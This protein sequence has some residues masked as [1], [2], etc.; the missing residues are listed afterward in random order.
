LH[1]IVGASWYFS[2]LQL[3]GDLE[4]PYIAKHITNLGQRLNSNIL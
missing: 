2:D 4:N 1:I 3:H